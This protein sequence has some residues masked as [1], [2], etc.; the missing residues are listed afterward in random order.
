MPF[1][2]AVV[3]PQVGFFELLF[4]RFESEVPPPPP[5]EPR[6]KISAW[7]FCVS[8]CDLIGV[9]G[10]A[11]APGGL[12]ELPEYLCTLAVLADAQVMPHKPW[13]K[14]GLSS[15]MMALTVSVCG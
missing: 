7:V 10:G 8:R 2:D 4:E 1:A 6:T 5:A 11:Q 13:S 14:H 12:V 15:N 9:P 3:R